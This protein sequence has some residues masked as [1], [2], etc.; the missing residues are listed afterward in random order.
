MSFRASHTPVSI[1]NS[2][3][4]RAQGCSPTVDAPL[5]DLKGFLTK[6]RDSEARVLVLVDGP[7]GS[8]ES[9]TTDACHKDCGSSATSGGIRTEVMMWFVCIAAVAELHTASGGRCANHW[10]T[11][12]REVGRR[13]TVLL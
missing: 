13:S 4:R 1:D 11:R 3:P 10:W 7:L 8:G 5:T 2:N 6:I 12:Y 9:A